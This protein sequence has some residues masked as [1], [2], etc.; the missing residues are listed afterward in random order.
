MESITETNNL[1]PNRQCSSC[2]V[3]RDMMLFKD[4]KKGDYFKTCE[5]CRMSKKKYRDKKRGAVEEE[6][7][8]STKSKS[9]SSSSGESA[10]LSINDIWMTTV[11]SSQNMHLIIEKHIECCGKDI[12]WEIEGERVIKIIML[13]T[14][15][16]FKVKEGETWGRIKRRIPTSSSS[17]SRAEKTVSTVRD[18]WLGDG[19]AD[20]TAELLKDMTYEQILEIHICATTRVSELNIFWIGEKILRYCG[21]DL[22]VKTFVSSDEIEVWITERGGGFTVELGDTWFESREQLHCC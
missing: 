2:K 11:V 10:E 22:V 18:H 14:G 9:S 5:L 15:Q 21:N 13:R 19:W 8:G 17:S 6:K 16:H 1:N 7:E 4:I 20:M 12:S 3:L